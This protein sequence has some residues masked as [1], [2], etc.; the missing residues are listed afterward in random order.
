MRLSEESHAGSITENEG[1]VCPASA[2]ESSYAT[3]PDSPSFGF[4]GLTT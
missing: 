3:A 4:R 1:E 2:V